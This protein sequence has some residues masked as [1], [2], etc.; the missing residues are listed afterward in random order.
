MEVTNPPLSPCYIAND[1]KRIMKTATSTHAFAGLRRTSG[2]RFSLLPLLS[3][4]LGGGAPAQTAGQVVVWGNNDYGQTNV[5]IAAQSGVIAIASGWDHTL[6]L[7]NDGSVVAW[8]WNSSGQTNVP[9]V[10][11]SEVVAID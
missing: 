8:G 2:T 11:Q 9:I 7:K 10:A 3:T 4:W 6:A 1:K 5:P